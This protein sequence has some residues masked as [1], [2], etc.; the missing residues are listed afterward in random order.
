MRTLADALRDHDPYL[1]GLR[2]DF[3]FAALRQ[4]QDFRRLALSV[5]GS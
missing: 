3:R 2:I 5:G 1:V 4:S